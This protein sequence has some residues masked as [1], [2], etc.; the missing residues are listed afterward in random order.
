MTEQTKP[1]FTETKLTE[2]KT[3]M[4]NMLTKVVEI[5]VSDLFITAEF[6]PSVKPKA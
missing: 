1:N 6:L 2:A 4:Y 3:I 5:G